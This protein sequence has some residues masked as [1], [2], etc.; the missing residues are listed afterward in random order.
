MDT[1]LKP[2]MLVW[3][4]AQGYRHI[5]EVMSFTT[6]DCTVVVRR[7]PGNSSTL[8]EVDADLIAS[9][10]LSP[11]PKSYKYVHYAVVAGPRRSRGSFPVDM[12]RYDS[13]APVNFAIDD[14]NNATVDASF[15]YGSEVLIVADVSDKPTPQWNRARW[16]SFGWVIRDLHTE[17]LS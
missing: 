10:L 9:P 15:G 1:E 2:Y 6:P 5:V 11:V 13:A 7:V 17:G 16:S 8:Q 12:L 3:L 14:E 4:Q